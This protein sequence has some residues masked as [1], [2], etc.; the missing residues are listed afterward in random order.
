MIMISTKCRI[1]GTPSAK[2]S[3]IS[4]IDRRMPHCGPLAART[5]I[6]DALISNRSLSRGD[7]TERVAYSEG[8]VVSRAGP[9]KR[10]RGRPP[11][12]NC[13]VINGFP[14]RL[15][16]GAPLRDVPGKY[17]E[18]IRSIGSPTVELLGCLGER[19]HRSAGTQARGG[20][21]KS[22]AHCPRHHGSHVCL[23]SR[24][25]SGPVNELLAAQG[26]Q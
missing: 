17:G 5:Q 25:K 11:E 12:A 22:T 13:N 18:G 2:L 1:K 21:I 23:S 9:W 7:L 3:G 10:C 19:R 8:F 16:I 4:R 24:R 14:P 20:T 26:R 6:S 15:R